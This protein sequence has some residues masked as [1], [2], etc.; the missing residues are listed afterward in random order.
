LAQENIARDFVAVGI[1]GD[2]DKSFALFEKVLPTYLGGILRAYHRKSVWSRA[3]T[4]K[5][6]K[7]P[8]AKITSSATTNSSHNNRSAEVEAFLKDRVLHWEYKLYAGVLD[9]FQK[10]LRTCDLL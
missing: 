1:V 10:H 2:L 4:P 9:N 5:I 3:T 6:I 8:A 7:T